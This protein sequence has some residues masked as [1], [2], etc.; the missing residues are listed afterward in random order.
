M[1]RI[2]LVFILV[3]F[4][5]FS[6]NFLS[7]YYPPWIVVLI[8][9]LP[10][11]IAKLVA[12]HFL[13]QV[14][15]WIRPVC[16]GTSW[17]IAGILMSVKP[18]SAALLFTPILVSA[19]TALV[20]ISFLGMTRYYGETALAGWGAGMGTGAVYYAVLALIFPVWMESSQ[21][22]FIDCI[23]LLTGAM[24]MA[25][26]VILPEAPVI[27]LEAQKSRDGTDVQVGALQ[28]AI[29]PPSRP[30]SAENRIIMTKA[31]IYPYLVPLFF[32]FA[33]QAAVFP[34]TPQILPMSPDFKTFFSYFANYRFA[35]HFGGFISRT[36][37]LLFHAHSVPVPN[38][39]L[40]LVVTI[41]FLYTTL[42]LFPSYIT[43]ELFAFGA[44]LMGGGIYMIVLSKLVDE[45][46]F[47]GGLD[48][49]FCLQIAGAGEIAGTIL[50]EILGAIVDG[51]VDG[52][53]ST[54][55]VIRWV[56]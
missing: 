21:H 6:A 34:S 32:T 22:N 26:F 54:P 43:M 11:F 28:H 2:E 15:Y 55:A 10:A 50:G 46:P 53:F 5:I 30:M 45:N 20:E 56:I 4:I 25:V 44:G 29:E 41:L 31:L 8:E 19:A 1:A 33:A 23:C 12:P 39:V 13:H 17:I 27:Y 36:F 18:S 38:I 35:F 49:E 37:A 24:L 14:P 48:R 9:K 51:G 7:E 3:P 40:T 47:E 16:V 52:Q 42:H